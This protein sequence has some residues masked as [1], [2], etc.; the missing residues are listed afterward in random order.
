ML[1]SRPRCLWWCCL[2][3]ATGFGSGVVVD[4]RSGTVERG[5]VLDV[6][7]ALFPRAGVV[8]AAEVAGEEGDRPDREDQAGKRGNSHS[9][10]SS[11][12]LYID[13]GDY[14]IIM[15]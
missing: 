13:K 9:S 12:I 7:I 8:V 3:A 6:R 14:Q 2:L 4:R 10:V 1:L 5:F 11:A 15:S